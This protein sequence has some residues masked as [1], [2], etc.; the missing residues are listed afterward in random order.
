MDDGAPVRADGD[1][2]RASIDRNDGEFEALGPVGQRFELSNGAGE[3][4]HRRDIVR[5]IL[6]FRGCEH[7][8]EIHLED[9]VRVAKTIQ[10]LLLHHN[11]GAV[12]T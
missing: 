4:P 5:I 3:V 2:V 11:E 12:S 7:V 8:L 9:E 1:D 10:R 6:V